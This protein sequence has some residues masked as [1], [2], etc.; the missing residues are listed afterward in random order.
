MKKLLAII[1]GESHLGARV[2]LSFGLLIAVLLSVGWVG[3][4]QLRRVDQ[5]LAKMVDQRWEKVQLARKAQA[6]SNI[7]NRLTMQ[8]FLVD[9]PEIKALMVERSSNSE[10]ISRLIETLRSRVESKEEEELL[11]AID[12]KRNPYIDSYKRA[13]RSLVEGKNPDAARAVMVKQALPGLI[14]YHDA[15]NAYVD[16]QG[17]QMDLAKEGNAV[18][19]A[20][21]RETTVLLTAF[22]V[23][24]AITMAIFV[25]RNITWHMNKIKRADA[26]MRQAHDELEE[27]VRGRT[28]ELA[29]AND[30]LAAEISEHKQ[31]E[32]EEARLTAILQA[33]TDMVATADLKG[34]VQYINHAGRKMLG[35]S[36]DQDV[37]NTRIADYH[38]EW[39]AS[40]VT[41]VGIPAAIE[42]GFWSGE[43]ALLSPDGREIPLSQ[44][45]IAHTAPDGTL[46]YLS[47]IGRDITERKRIEAKIL[48]EQLFSE[49]I[50][51]SLPGIFYLIDRAGKF[52]RWN[53][54]FEQV[55][56]YSAEEIAT[57]SPVDLFVG[58]EKELIAQ[59]IQEVFASGASDAEAHLVSK[60]GQRTPYYFTGA[61]IDSNDQPCLIGLGLDITER[62]RAEAALRESEERYRDLFENANDIIYTH[63]LEGNYTSVNKAC[64]RIAGY[65]QDESM[66][67]NVSQVIAPEY[68]AMARNMVALKATDAAPPVYELEIIHKD[69]HRVVLE[70]NSRLTYEGTRPTGVQGMARDI[71]ERKRAEADIR[72]LQELQAAIL[73]GVQ[74]GIQGIDKAGRIAFANPIAAGM[75]GWHVNELIGKPAHAT[76]H[77]HHTDGN[78]YPA[79][80]CNIYATLHDGQ[81]RHI[82]DEAFWRQDG[83]SFPVEYTVAPMH[84]ISGEVTGTVVVFDD[85]SERKHAE[86]G[87]RESEERYR[88][89][90]DSNPQPMWV[91]D[92]ETLAFLAVNDSAVHHYGY[93][94]EDFL[95]MTIKDIRPAEDLPALLASVAGPSEA[96]GAVSIWRH[97]KKDGTI[98]EVE[99][100]SHLLVFDDRRAELIL[101]Q[102]ITER[103]KLENALQQERIFLRTLIDNIPDSV[104]VKDMACR[105][106]IANLTEV[107]IAGLQ[108]EADLLGKDDF[109]LHP[110]ELAEK[111]FADD[112]VVLQTGQPVVNREEYVLSKQGKK[113]WLLTTKIPLRDENGQINGLLGLGRDITERKQADEALK[114]S[115]ERYRTIIE[116]MTDGYVETDL[117]GKLTFINNQTAIAMR[118]SREKLMGLSNKQYMDEETVKRVGAAYKQVYLTGEPAKGL[119]FEI[120]RDDG[121][122]YYVETNVSLIRDSQGKP[123][124]FRGISRDVTKRKQIEDQMVEARDVA[125]ESVRLKSEFLANMSHEIR[126]PMNGVIGMTGLLL[127]TDLD[128]EQRDCA[129]TIRASGE[130]LL[131]IINDILDFSKIEAGKLQFETL[132][133]LLNNAVEDTIELLAERAHRKKIEF[134]SLIY[135]D[136]PTGLQGDPGRLR[137]VLTNLIGNAIKFTDHGEVIVRVEK[138]TETYDDVVV[139]FAVS[140]TGIGI[141]EAAQQTL[142]QAFTQADG[143][144]TRKYGGTGLGLAISK[145]LV[146]LMGGQMGVES[147]PGQGSTFWFTARFGKQLAG[148]VIRQPQLMSLENL[149]VLIVDDNATNRK[150]LSHQV[151]SWGMNHQ[152]A[153][154]GFHALEL[155]RAAAAEGAAYD[156]AVL[157]LMMPGM[158]GF[159]LARTIKSDPSIA[160]MHLVMLTSFGERGHG[161]AAREAGV[162]AY[163][164]KP[165]RQSQLF[166]CLANVISAAAVT[167][168]QD[169]TSSQRASELL[170]KH[171]LKEAK[172][173]S[174]KLILLA[175]DNIVNQK[176][177]IRQLAKLGYRADAVANGREAI[178]ALSRIHYDLV[179]MDCQMPEMDGYEATA[180]IRRQENGTRH[181][182]VVAMTAHA[183]TGDREKCTAAGMDEYITK[184]VKAEELERVLELFC[185]T[186]SPD[187]GDQPGPNSAPLVDVDR[188]HEM[189]G[190]GPVELEEIVNL[191]LD[192]MGQSLNKLD[193][194]VASGNHVDVEL[195][196]HNCAGTSANC[197]M[198][199]VAIPFRELEDAGRAGCLENAPATLAQAHEFFEQ[200]RAFLDQH[201]F[202]HAR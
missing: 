112:Q 14:E 11:N 130:A 87:L 71:T 111:F 163:L 63:D 144:T 110:K 24:F 65:T 22:A 194:A 129:E 193:A 50:V 174:N 75:L 146:E 192:Q 106:V 196:A 132:D 199:A 40:I 98:I 114:Q 161:A 151:A 188:M 43:T 162:A 60:S 89:L 79:E 157:D 121:T 125:L 101:A 30:A 8:V 153:V 78:S 10:K 67:M 138:E 58:E 26:A 158:D 27:R 190:D 62:K 104:Y 176:V 116:D 76:M 142:F 51:N 102:D 181:T 56:G 175:E 94:R 103:K 12:K 73:S 152:E 147:T 108:S 21:T 180:E 183:L 202:Q 81:P 39:A 74:H 201:V 172:M 117:A 149:R 59:R 52:T 2:G 198:N 139:R 36:E 171:T 109:E 137:Q 7:N 156:L 17:H 19:G 92:L 33:T 184:P 122:S 170:T 96:F 70:I 64:E 179:L 140:D 45:I 105:K 5:D 6:L 187:S 155:L 182:P 80:D 160:G 189:M 135:G 178:E 119:T 141:S 32:K 91:Y 185:K 95:A 145:Q 150:I 15:W 18:T 127:D 164:T 72:G 136:V 134:A 173:S 29:K 177:A 57:L 128:E 90:F 53:K 41:N 100:T 44:V 200:T 126:T 113:S 84:S 55:T 197:G 131:T 107:R 9:E 28:A 13:L 69:G 42:S 35:L 148:A 167:S 23:L 54:N 34:F 85:I 154:S 168:E 47:T 86:E 46:E 16:Y 25:T 37:T 191:Y 99:I 93:S 66:K 195:I 49:S 143:S 120:N 169:D 165:V 68:L 38:A 4:R 118:R 123:V 115:E 48:G 3:I 186:P 83:T 20:A 97:L 1:F 124:G 88:L 166:D 159:E 77:H 82:L 31:T 61:R 133:F